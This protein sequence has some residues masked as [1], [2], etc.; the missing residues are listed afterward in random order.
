LR[1][2]LDANVVLPS[3][4]FTV[5]VG[6]PVPGATAATVAVKVTVWPNN[7][8]LAAEVRVV[9]VDAGLTTWGEAKSLPVDA[10]KLVSPL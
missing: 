9:V 1:V 8:G 2:T 6:V 5:P 3:K 7:D 4:K 10:W